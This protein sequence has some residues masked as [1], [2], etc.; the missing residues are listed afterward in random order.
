MAD[1][2]RGLTFAATETVTADKLHQIVDDATVSGIVDADVAAG[3]AIED[4]KLADI[5]TAG[6]V[7]TTA[8]TTTSQ[9][10][11]DILYNNGSGYVRLAKGTALQQL[12]TNAATTAP[13]WATY[14]IGTVFGAWTTQQN[15]VGDAGVANY[16]KDLVYLA[17]TDGLVLLYNTD[18]GNSHATTILTDSSNPPT[19]KRADFTQTNSLSSPSIISL[20][21]P[22]RKGDYWKFT[23]NTTYT[24][25]WLPIGS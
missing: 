14:A 10:A 23:A 18:V 20:M 21:C 25:Y 8:L 3:A 9:A 5:S 7:N 11:G 22:V 2:S 1:V 24:A 19:T 4:T 17:A 16:T 6:K 12:R 13:E 15:D